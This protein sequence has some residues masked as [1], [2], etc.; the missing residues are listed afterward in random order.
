MSTGIMFAQA[1]PDTDYFS[2]LGSN[3]AAG[4]EW[5]WR[6]EIEWQNQDELVIIAFNISPR[7]KESKAV[8]TKYYRIPS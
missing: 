5:G 6:T 8:E 7:G 2:V 1:D 3:N 4:E